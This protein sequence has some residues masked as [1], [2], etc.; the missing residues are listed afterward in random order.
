MKNFPVIICCMLLLVFISCSRKRIPQKPA[1]TIFDTT[2]VNTGK[3]PVLIDSTAKAD[4]GTTVITAARVL[5]IADGY[6]R[7]ITPQ[8][9]LPQDT[10][11]SYNNLQLS[12]GFTTQQR[13]NM[14]ARY[15]TIPPRVLY[16]PQQYARSSLKGSYYIY[17]NKFWYWK[18]SDGLFY[19]DEK[20]YL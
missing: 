1:T 5:V 11:I 3:K 2:S 4:S 8:Q 20:Y 6:G 19:L 18:K 12:K 16:V 13:A 9:N 14:Q 10:G 15:K 7:L 17:N